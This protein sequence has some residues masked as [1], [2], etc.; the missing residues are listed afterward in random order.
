MSTVRII[1]KFKIKQII[2][3]TRKQLVVWHLSLNGWAIVWSLGHHWLQRVHV[4]AQDLP[5]E[6]KLYLR[7]LGLEICNKVI[8]LILLWSLIF[9]NS[10]SDFCRCRAHAMLVLVGGARLGLG[11]SLRLLLKSKCL[12]R[13]R[14]G[15]LEFVDALDIWFDFFLWLTSWRA[16]L[17]DFSHFLDFQ[18]IICVEWLVKLVL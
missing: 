6:A 5:S 2:F 1:S 17:G 7:L 9:E 8:L 3:F 18:R 12:A 15:L 10:V 4:K 13:E 14:F 16:D 11:H